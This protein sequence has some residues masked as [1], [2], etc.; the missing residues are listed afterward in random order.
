M[1]ASKM[2][3]KHRFHDGKVVL[4]QLEGRPKQL[5]L[6]RI[7]VPGGP[8]YILRG[9]G[10][11]DLYEARKF[12]DEVLDELK[13]KVR[14]GQSVT[15][16][17]VRKMVQ[18]YEDHAKLKGQPTRREQAILAFLK[19]Y[20]IPYFT[21]AKVSDLTPPEINRFFDWRRANSKRKAPRETTIIHEMSQL[22]TFLTWCY[23]RGL[24]SKPVEI[25]N[26]KIKGSRRPHFSEADWMKLSKA[27]RRLEAKKDGQ[28]DANRDHVMLANYVWIL[29]ATG[30]RV[31]EARNLRWGDIEQHT[32]KRKGIVHVIFHVKGKTGIREVVSST[33]EVKQNLDRLYEMR[34]KEAGVKPKPADYIFCHK[35]GLPI[36]SFKKGFHL[37]IQKAGVERDRHGERRTLYSL[38]HTYATFRLHEGVNHYVLAR[39]MGTSVKMLEA[40]YGH[41]S[42]RVMAE[43]LTKSRPQP[44][45]WGFKSAVEQND[46]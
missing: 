21:K 4:Y 35:D 14:S 2:I 33:P 11:S 15:G 7:K 36:H 17:N 31:G 8:G 28:R 34:T 18:E 27:L 30:I 13:Y 26:V 41:T 42:N 6:C 37:L 25:E 22:R 16:L 38:R 46:S 45:I 20:A 9:S 32:E 24:I 3:N 10:T 40:H 5:W 44:S 12:A 1:P 43:E 19:T 39:N 29:F 23:R